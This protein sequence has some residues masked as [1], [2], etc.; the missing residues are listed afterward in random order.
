METPTEQSE[1]E[2]PSGEGEDLGSEVSVR[3]IQILNL[4]LLAAISAASLWISKE[5]A[6]GVV[7][8]GILMAANFRVLAGVMRAVFLKGAGSLVHVGIYWAK[9]AGVLLLVGVLVLAF[10]VD[11]VGFLLGLSTIL[12]AVTA[13]AVL[14]L[15][16]K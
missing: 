9:F 4:F 2:I 7:A 3:R 15:A 14:R 16:G 12:V 6:L 8:G 1:P 13:E 10:R 5:F 11:P